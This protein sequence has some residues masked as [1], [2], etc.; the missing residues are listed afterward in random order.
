MDK[1][2]SKVYVVIPRTWGELSDAD[3]MA[4]VRSV[5]KAMFNNVGGGKN[6]SGD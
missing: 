4:W 5:A 1:Q 6:E 3:K 2:N